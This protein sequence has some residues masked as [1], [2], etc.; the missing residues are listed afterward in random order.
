MLK[1]VLAALVLSLS[2]SVRAFAAEEKKKEGQSSIKIEDAA[3]QK[4]K[5]AGDIDEDITNA[6]LRA[7]S[8]SKS[9]WSGSFTASYYGASLEKPLDKDRPNTNQEPTPPKVF[10]GGDLGIRYRMNKKDSIS[11]GTGYS[12]I[13][14]FHEAKK[15]NISDPYVAYNHATKFGGVQNYTTAALQASTDHDEVVLGEIG[16]LDVANTMMYDFGGSKASVGLAVEGIYA[17]F[18][19]NKNAI[20]QWTNDDGSPDRF[21]AGLRQRNETIVIYPLAEFALTDKITFRT[22]FRPLIFDHYVI[23]GN[24]QNSGWAK[25]RWTQ[26]IGMGFAVTRDIYLYPNFQYDWYA[27]QADDFN[28]FRQNTRANSTVGLQATIN[29]F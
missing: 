14:P 16:N 19:N 28:W 24:T 18:R 25:R 2:F 11:L 6:K 29:V 15:G 1:S 10:M 21:T 7:E 27:W 4:N 5:V 17:Q 20:A 22:V 8:G 23:K 12:L 3:N 9:K 26:S 13:R